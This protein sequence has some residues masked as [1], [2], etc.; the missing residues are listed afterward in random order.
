MSDHTFALAHLLGF[1]FVPRIPN[2]AARKLYA[3]SPAATWPTL[4]PFIGGR[5]DEALIVAQWDDV[6]RL[7]TSVRTG[8]VSAV[9]RLRR[10]TPQEAVYLIESAFEISKQPGSRSAPIGTPAVC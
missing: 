7:A 3:F 10:Q 2:V 6:L 1:R 9:N 8:A 5:I 4:A